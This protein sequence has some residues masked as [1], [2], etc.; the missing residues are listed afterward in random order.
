LLGGGCQNCVGRLICGE[1]AAPTIAHTHYSR[2]SSTR[3][4]DVA[5][6][7]DETAGVC[8]PCDTAGSLRRR[9]GVISSPSNSSSLARR[10][11]ALASEPSEGRL[12][13]LTRAPPLPPLLVSNCVMPSTAEAML[14]ERV[15]AHRLGSERMWSGAS[16]LVAL[17]LLAAVDEAGPA[18]CDARSSLVGESRL[19]PPPL[20]RESK[21]VGASAAAALL[22]V[23]EATAAATTAAANVT[24]VLGVSTAGTRWPGRLRSLLW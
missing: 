6:V 10:T 1:R 18:T 22:A 21:I 20:P 3:A 5:D 11:R 8:A 7:A 17:T 12:R 24:A 2:S 9:T 23:A 19:L 13:P 16:A 15:G 4:P 14:I